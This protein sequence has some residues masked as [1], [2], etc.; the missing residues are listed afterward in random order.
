MPAARAV[1]RRIRT[2][3]M[4]NVFRGGECSNIDLKDQPSRSAAHVGKGAALSVYTVTRSYVDDLQKTFLATTCN[5]HGIGPNAACQVLRF[6][7][8]G[9]RSAR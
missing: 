8:G 3:F 4:I 7:S 5:L 2:G 9:Q 6:A 1:A